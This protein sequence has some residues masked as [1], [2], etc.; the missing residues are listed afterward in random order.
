MRQMVWYPLLTEVGIAENLVEIEAPCVDESFQNIPFYEFH[1]KVQRGFGFHEL[2]NSN[3]V[4]MS[5]ACHGLCLFLE[6]L[7]EIGI[8]VR[9]Y[10]QYFESR[11]SVEFRV[12]CLIIGAHPAVSDEGKNF[13]IWKSFL[14]FFNTWRYELGSE[15]SEFGW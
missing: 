5:E 4:G 13:Q 2:I 15:V 3:D 12:A 6:T 11:K 1:H 7:D 9:I 10:G 14:Q 8:D